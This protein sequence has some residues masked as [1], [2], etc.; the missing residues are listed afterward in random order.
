MSYYVKEHVH[1]D[2]I[3][4]VKQQQEVLLCVN[5][6]CTYCKLFLSKYCIIDAKD[7]TTTVTWYCYITV[8]SPSHTDSIPINQTV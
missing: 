1:L 6:L 5:L 8:L 4:P 7:N 2:S 3:P